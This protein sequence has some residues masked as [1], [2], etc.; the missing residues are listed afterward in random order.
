MKKYKVF[1]TSKV[2]SEYRIEANSKEEAEDV[3]LADDPDPIDTHY[4]DTEFEI[5]EIKE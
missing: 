3:V 5:E 4:Y 2:M 1:E